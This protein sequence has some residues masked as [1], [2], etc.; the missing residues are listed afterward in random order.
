MYRREWDKS[1]QHMQ[2]GVPLKTYKARPA[3]EGEGPSDAM[4]M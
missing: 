4:D 2:D 1:L 3:G